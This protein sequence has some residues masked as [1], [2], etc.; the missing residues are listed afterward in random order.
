[1]SSGLTLATVSREMGLLASSG[2][3]SAVS[4]HSSMTSLIALNEGNAE[5]PVEI[6]GRATRTLGR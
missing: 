5:Q 1:M 2:K 3:G 6:D 4:H